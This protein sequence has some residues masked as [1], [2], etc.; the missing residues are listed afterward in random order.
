M[1]NITPGYMSPNLRWG[2]FTLDHPGSP[3]PT[4]R[5]ISPEAAG[6]PAEFCK[7]AAGAPV[8]AFVRC[9]LRDVH[10]HL[11]ATGDREIPSQERRR[12]GRLVPFTRNAENWRKLRTMAL[13]RALKAAGYPDTTS[14][15]KNFLLYRQRLVEL[16]SDAG[17]GAAT[18]TERVTT[19]AELSSGS[20]ETE[21]DVTETVVIEGSHVDPSTGEIIDTEDVEIEQALAEESEEVTVE[22]DDAAD[23]LDAETDAYEDAEEATAEAPS[24]EPAATKWPPELVDLVARLGPA[25]QADLSDWL[26]AAGYTPDIL[27]TRQTAIR[28]VEK[29]IKALLT[30]SGLQ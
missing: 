22:V 3:E 18:L 1:P 26:D 6:V 25:E 9:E 15:L 16:G 24:E 5:L 10:K 27:F 17:M 13:G 28:A 20:N 11:V 7:D 19:A 8:T 2:F 23:Q 4:Y 29:K 14:D 30:A 12:D 21:V